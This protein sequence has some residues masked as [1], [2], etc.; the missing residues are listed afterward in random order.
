M[1]P[2]TKIALIETIQWA[3]QAAL[4]AGLLFG[5]YVLVSSIV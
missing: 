2:D 3:I 4:C 1:D 5:L